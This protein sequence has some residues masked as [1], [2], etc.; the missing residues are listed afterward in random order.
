MGLV[1]SLASS[2]NSS[3]LKSQ[4]GEVGR[5]VGGGIMT[6]AF[7]H[8]RLKLISHHVGHWEREFICVISVFAFLCCPYKDDFICSFSSAS[9]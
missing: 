9:S 3:H 7:S 4:M 6:V 5:V 1:E 2:F 8:C